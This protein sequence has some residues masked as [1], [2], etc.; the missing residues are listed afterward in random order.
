MAYDL[1]ETSQELGRPIYL[2]RFILGTSLW[3]YTSADEDVVFDGHNWQA[4]PISDE[5]IGQTGEAATDALRITADAS[6]G[7]VLAFRNNPPSNTI[8]VTIFRAHEGDLSN[9]IT[10]YVGEV[11]E[12]DTPTPNSASITCET[13]SATMR[14]AGLRLGWQR[15]C[16]YALYDPLTCKVEKGLYGVAGTI[17]AI[18]GFTINV[19]ALAAYPAGRFAGGFIE[20]VDPIRGT[21]RRMI[22]SQLG[23]ALTIFGTTEDLEIGM[24]LTIYPGCA[25]TMDACTDFDNLPNYGGYPHMPGKSPFDGDPVFY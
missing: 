2:Y 19:A 18:S 15:T 8:Q 24:P 23:G 9:F 5:G 22:E 10:A 11:T 12:V 4:V 20:W 13:L 25:R 21:E 14:R 16:P 1:I 6:I 3:R 17:G 7:P